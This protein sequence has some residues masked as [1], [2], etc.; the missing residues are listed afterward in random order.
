[1][2]IQIVTEAVTIK[3]PKLARPEQNPNYPANPPTFNVQMVLV[4]GEHDE[5]VKK[6]QKAID[7]LKT[8]KA[9]KPPASW[10]PNDKGNIELRASSREDRRPQVVDQTTTP[11]EPMLIAQEL[12]GGAV[13]KV[14]IDLYVNKT[15]LICVGL[16]AVQK[17]A[18]G[19]RIG[20]EVPDAADLFAPLPVTGSALD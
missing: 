19:D 7:G 17:V 20:A 9:I 16:L 12:Y 1:M 11:I 6:I 13:C 5:T 8:T 18:D 10:E 3:W 15:N 2:G 14:A 4:P